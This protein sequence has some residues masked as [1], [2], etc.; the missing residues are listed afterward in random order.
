MDISSFN[1]NRYSKGLLQSH[2][3]KT[4]LKSDYDEIIKKYEG[5]D[6]KW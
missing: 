5:I 1:L 2:A 6:K 4:I 3:K